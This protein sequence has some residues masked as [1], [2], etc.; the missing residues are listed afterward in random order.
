VLAGLHG[1]GCT[2][3]LLSQC[4]WARQA[5]PEEG[6]QEKIERLQ[7]TPIE[8]KE[9]SKWLFGFRETAARTPPGVGLIPVLSL[10]E[11]TVADRGSDP[12]IPQ[13]RLL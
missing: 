8:E 5:V 7:C 13:D 6:H 3:G 4:I 11:G 2:L 12:S 10:V 9:S 1:L